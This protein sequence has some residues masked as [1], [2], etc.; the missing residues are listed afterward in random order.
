MKPDAKGSQENPLSLLDLPFLVPETDRYWLTY[1]S[2]EPVQLP[3]SPKGS[4]LDVE[5]RLPR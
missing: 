5:M 2:D 1:G 3:L 4:T